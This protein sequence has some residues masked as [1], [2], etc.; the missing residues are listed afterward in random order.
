M[1]RFRLFGLCDGSGI[2]Q[3]FDTVF[4]DVELFDINSKVHKMVP[5]QIRREI[6]GER[7]RPEESDIL[8]DRER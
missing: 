4:T 7:C 3:Y 8:R 2:F 6:K 1:N 5:S